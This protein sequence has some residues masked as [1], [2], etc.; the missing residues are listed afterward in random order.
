MMPLTSAHITRFAD[1]NAVDV[2]NCRIRTKAADGRG[3]NSQH[4]GH[5]HKGCDTGEHL[6]AYRRAA[7]FQM[8]EIFFHVAPLRTLL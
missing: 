1:N 5:C 4:I 3:L 7:L 2:R 8:K 6:T